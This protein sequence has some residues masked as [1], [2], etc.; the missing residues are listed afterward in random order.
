M[1]FQVQ[2]KAVNQ[3]NYRESARSLIQQTI[4]YLAQQIAAS[5]AFI[6]LN[7]KLVLLP[8]YFLTG[9]P[10]LGQIKLVEK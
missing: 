3:A 4:N 5:K 6:G 10:Q 9:F 2:A 7:C 1:A 8:E